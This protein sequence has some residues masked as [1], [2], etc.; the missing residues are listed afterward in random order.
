[1]TTPALSL[2]STAQL[3]NTTVSIPRLGFGTYQ[4]TGNA[5]TT[6]CLQ[7]FAAGYRHIDSAQLYGNEAAVGEA[8]RQSGLRREDVFLTSKV[9]RS[10]GGDRTYQSLV[11]SVVKLAGEGGYVDLFLVHI[12]GSSRKFRQELWT[13]VERLHAN[14]LARSIGVSNFRTQHIEEMK[15]YATLHPW[16]QQ[17]ELV[18]Y[19]QANGIVVEAYSPLA[20]GAEMQNPSLQG[21]A[22]K[23]GKSAAQVLIRYCLQKDW[24]ALPKSGNAERIRQNADIYGFELDLDDMKTLDALDEGADGGRFGPNRRR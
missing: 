13:A 3:I 17:R 12:P 16:F 6:A 9:C 15:E 2:K 10:G 14:G 24:V 19:C 1:M 11:D 21:V 8:V 5:C 4:I 22:S 18:Q 7:A 20:T 23:H